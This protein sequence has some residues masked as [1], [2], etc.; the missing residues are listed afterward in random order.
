[1][2]GQVKGW[3]NMNNWIITDDD[4]FQCCKKVDENVY[5]FVE[6]REYFNAEFSS[7]EV[8]H[9]HIYLEDYTEDEIKDTIY[10]YGYDSCEQFKSNDESDKR[11]LAEMLFECSSSFTS[12]ENEVYDTFELAA[13]R[14]TE[15]TGLK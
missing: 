9:V 10:L 4:C 3:Y 14:I 6:I 11:I 5:E 15:I 7:F 2:C 8:F 12:G 13:N 1:V